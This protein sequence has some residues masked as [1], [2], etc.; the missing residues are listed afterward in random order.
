MLN[1]VGFVSVNARPSSNVTCRF[2]VRLIVLLVRLV[3]PAHRV[4]RWASVE[5]PVEVPV[6]IRMWLSV[7]PISVGTLRLRVSAI[8][9]HG[10]QSPCFGILRFWRLASLSPFFSTSFWPFHLAILSCLVAP[11][12]IVLYP[13]AVPWNWRIG[14]EGTSHSSTEDSCAQ[15][16]SSES[17][18]K[19]SILFTTRYLVRRRCNGVES[20]GGSNSPLPLLAFLNLPE[21]PPKN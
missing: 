13:R 12:Y 1:F 3:S 4:A 9:C 6:E 8:R 18:R 21:N 7:C 5:V 14:T 15:D 11:L 20:N 10:L 16:F 2:V 17:I 19:V